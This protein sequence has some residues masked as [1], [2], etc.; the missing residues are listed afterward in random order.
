MVMGSPKDAG[1]VQK[2][3][4]FKWPIFF[5]KIWGKC[6][7]INPKV[8]ENPKQKKHKVNNIRIIIHC[9]KP[10][11]HQKSKKKKSRLKKGEKNT[12]CVKRNKGK[13]TDFLSEV[14]LV[15]LG[16]RRACNTSEIKMKN[17][18]PI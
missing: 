14:I 10:V 7:Q 5:S 9:L 2:N 11:K 4:F 13:M 12:Y 15:L 17:K 1:W 8:L 6:K 18:L 3:I 16:N